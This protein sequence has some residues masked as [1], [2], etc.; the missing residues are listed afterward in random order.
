M[1]NEAVP[2]CA[3]KTEEGVV[4][5][6]TRNAPAPVPLHGCV[7]SFWEKLPLFSTGFFFQD[8]K[9]AGIFEKPN[10][11][12]SSTSFQAPTQDPPLHRPHT[13]ALRVKTVSLSMLVSSLRSRK[14]PT[15]G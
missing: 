9:E 2:P 14:A 4:L 15:P 11:V 1:V 7:P 10:F 6:H 12:A 13:H 8:P 5:A 3:W